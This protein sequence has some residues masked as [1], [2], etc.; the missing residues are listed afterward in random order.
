MRLETR[1]IFGWGNTTA[2][3]APCLD[4][5]VVHYDGNNQGL[6]GKEHNECRNYWKRTRSFHVN[7]NG[8]RD[9]GY[10]FAVCPHGYVL[11]GRGWGR[12]QA[13]QPGGNRTWTSVTF[14]SG[15]SE[16][17]TQAQLQAFGELRSHLKAKGLRDGLKGHRDFY[18][19]DCPGDILYAMV[20]SGELK[21][22]HKEDEVSAKEVWDEIIVTDKD[23]DPVQT[24]KARTVLGH[25]EKEQDA[26]KS[27]L[28]QLNDK[29]EDVL[30]MLEDINVL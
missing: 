21:R 27:L 7:T 10:S 17:P 3:V 22:E 8:W 4:G 24:M 30:D 12:E 11:E 26:I 2:A 6:A 25:L 16:K 9:I 15:P 14:M 19:T 20:K 1:A 5:L 28:L 29:V 13:A 23:T 18:A